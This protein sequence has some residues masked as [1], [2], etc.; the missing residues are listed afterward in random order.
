MKEP[1]LPPDEH[2]RLAELR[3]L[4]IVDTPAEH[5]Y[6]AITAI[7]SH[8]AGTPMALVSLVD[9]DRQWF[10]AKVGLQA[11]ETPR[12]ISFCGHAVAS[13]TT[14]RVHDAR[15]DD[16][17]A[18]NPL[19]LG[20]PKIRF[21][22]GVPLISG[23]H[24]LGTLCVLD[25]QP[26]VLSEEVERMLALLA[27]QV[28]SQFE[29]RRRNHELESQR[30]ELS[31]Q[32]RFFD[33]S[34]ALLC[35]ADRD[36]RFRLLNPRWEVV[37][38]WSLEELAER[39][40]LHLLHPDDVDRTVAEATRLAERKTPT[41]DFE[42]RFRHRDGRWIT[43]SWVAVLDGET[44]LAAAHDLTAYREKAAALAES[45][46]RLRA[47]VETAADAV[48]T[49]DGRGVVEQVNPTCT[50]MFGAGP[51]EI[52][53]RP[54][55]ELVAPSHRDAPE[56]R[57]DLDLEDPDRRSRP[58]EFPAIRRD[59]TLFDAE[60][61]VAPFQLGAERRYTATVRDIS[62]RRRAER[63]QAEF[64]STVTHELRTPLT[65][66]RGALGLIDGGVLGPVSEPV[67]EYVGVALS[68]T[69]RL[70]RLIDD[71]LDLEKMRSGQMV[72]R[73]APEPVAALVDAA[74]A[75]TDG[76]AREHDAEVV[77]IGDVPAVEVVVDKDRMVQV[78]TNLISNAVKFTPSGQ[79]VELS[80]EHAAER[81]RL[82][83]RDHGPGVP[84]GFRDR[85]FQ[86]FAQADGS[87]RR[88]GTGLGLS[89]SKSIVDRH[90]GVLAF[91][92]APGGGTIFYVDLF[93]RE[94]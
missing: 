56:A 41:V 19:V 88:G 17:F 3:A 37:L 64:V 26:R 25:R 32:R 31:I 69:E 67:A 7:A 73:M 91:E 6:D 55:S 42:N 33:M 15:A 43:L 58:Y 79:R 24:A 50:R 75:A 9:A 39:P 22:H 83:I 53:G 94:P 59:G 74:L 2:G 23:G 11:T 18:D 72:Y 12:S 38:G 92:D 66:V 48:I 52:V 80:V 60:A 61:M 65:S 30:A 84:A 78:L 1:D 87:G 81:L 51:D 5:A 45:E 46:G 63:R 21:Y 8:V 34:L 44:F 13:G 4:D 27:D 86:R 10:K 85:I 82:R 57:F 36:L 77:V 89:I 90:G 20:E 70:G 40:F 76:F 54:V 49:F 71:V 29:L 68:N 35:T 16:R 14:L 47:I 28:V 62:E 93:A